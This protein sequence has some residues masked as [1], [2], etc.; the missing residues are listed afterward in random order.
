[1]F[2]EDDSFSTGVKNAKNWYGV[3]SMSH[4]RH[5]REVFCP[6]RG[7][8]VMEE[9]MLMRR[10]QAAHEYLARN[11]KTR[12]GRYIHTMFARG[13]RE[14]MSTLRTKVEIDNAIE[15][16]ALSGMQHMRDIFGP[17]GP[18]EKLH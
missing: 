8:M 13:L 7:H 9:L 11:Q 14:E 3:M 16:R 17:P 2:P 15:E 4:A 12:I 1:M 6:T 10:Q 5:R 18:E